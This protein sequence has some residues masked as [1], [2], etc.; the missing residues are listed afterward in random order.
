MEKKIKKVYK[1]I[2]PSE[3]VRLSNNFVDEFLFDKGIEIPINALRIIFNIASM[4]RNEQ[5]QADK[6]PT[7][8]KLFEDTFSSEHNTYAQMKIKNSLISSNGYHVK[9]AYEF[10]ENFKKDWYKFTTSD[11]RKIS[12]YGGLISNVFNEEKG[13]THFLISSYWVEKLVHI[14]SYNETLYNLVYKIK[15]NKHIIFWFWLAKVENTGT[16]ISRDLINKRYSLNYS[17]CKNLCKDFLKPIKTNFDKYSPLSFN[18]SIEGDNII[19]KPYSL[20]NIKNQEDLSLETVEKIK[21][22]YTVRYFRDRHKLNNDEIKG[23]K[24]IIE[25]NN[26]E[27]IILSDAYKEFIKYCRANKIKATQYTGTGFKETYQKFI[28]MEYLKTSIGKKFPHGFPRI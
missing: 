17:N 16:K 21:N 15:S 11:G 14:P 18:Y 27:S 4:L 8:L 1:E 20:K 10:L 12:A 28:E 5:F 19:I 26:I 3:I 7:Q 25:Q 6:A 9:K 24:H 23:I 13:Y 2:K 22:K